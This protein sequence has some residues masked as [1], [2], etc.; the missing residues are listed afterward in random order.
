MRMFILSHKR[1]DRVKTKKIF[2]SAALVVPASQEDD[3]RK[4]NPETEIIVHPD[5]VVGISPK[6][7]WVYS[8]FG[9]QVQLDDD[10]IGVHRMYRAAGQG[11]MKLTPVEAEALMHDLYH[12]AKE[13]GAKL[14]GLNCVS[15]P[16]HYAGERPIAFNKFIKGGCIGIMRDENLFFIDENYFIGEDAWICLL[17]AHFNRYSFID[18]RFSMTFDTTEYAQG[19]CAD[20]RTEERRREAYE[21]LKKSFGDGIQLKQPKEGKE[22]TKWEKGINI[23]Y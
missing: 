8:K 5:S 9:D 20:F 18:M 4:Y 15:N 12:V 14:W 2:P 3:Y 16:M 10:I 11:K 22:Y 21:I 17:N 7:Q 6:R 1:A 13:A 23:P 19:G